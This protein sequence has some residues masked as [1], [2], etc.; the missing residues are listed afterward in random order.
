M[1]RLEQNN[2]PL[3]LTFAHR[4]TQSHSRPTSIIHHLLSC[5]FYHLEPWAPPPP[6]PPP[7]PHR[8]SISTDVSRGWRCSSRVSHAALTSAAVALRHLGRLDSCDWVGGLTLS[9]AQLRPRQ[10]RES[11]WSDLLWWESAV[12]VLLLSGGNVLC[13][14]TAV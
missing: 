1:E 14:Y 6:P 10:L 12:C 3:G 2:V 11:S 9:P 4:R 8:P 5:T 13:V 7:P